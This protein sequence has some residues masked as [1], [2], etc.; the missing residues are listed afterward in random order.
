MA[1]LKLTLITGRSTK[2]GAGISSGK[3]YQD[4]KEAT[5]ILDM[6]CADMERSGL[7]EGDTARI[8]TRLGSAEVVC[9]AADIPEGL[10]FIA[11]GPACNTLVGDETYASG[12]PDSK[13]VEVEVMRI[14][15][16]DREMQTG[17]QITK[18]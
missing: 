8:A 2:Q 16:E 3:E 17:N 5:R 4:Y 13:H 12:M 15:P 18:S 6:N 1:N 9:R 7:A 11:F 14:V 10:A